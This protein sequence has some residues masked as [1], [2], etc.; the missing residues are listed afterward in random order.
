MKKIFNRN[1]VFL[2]LFAVT[3]I[4]PFAIMGYK[5]VVLDYALAGLMPVV[6][7]RV[8]LSMVVHGH[9]DDISIST[10]LPKT[11][12]RQKITD[13]ENSSGAFT[14]ALQSG[15]D[16]RLAT[17]NAESVS[18]EHNIRYT[19]S[20]QAGHVQYRIPP[21]MP[22]PKADARKMAE[23]LAEEAGTQVND[24]LIE[25]T[26]NEILPD[27]EVTLLEALTGIHRYLQ[28]S[29]KNKTFSGYT[30]A[31]TALKLGEASC[32]GKSRAFSAMLR[33]LN[34]PSR[35]VGGLI[36]QQGSKRVGHQWVEA[37]INGHWVP[38]DTINDHFAEIPSNY[39]TL[40]YGDLVLF[41]HTTNV[42]FQY[43]FKITKRL[44]PRLETQ[45]TL[46]NSM[47]NIFNI[48]SVFEQVGISQNL[49]KIMLMIPL[50]ALVTVVFRNVIG[51]ETFG[52]FLPALI[53]AAARETGLLWGVVGF[54]MVILVSALA[55]KVLDWLH[56]LH[57][58]K[59]AIMLTTVVVVML[60]TT[61]AGVRLGLFDLAHITLFPIAIMA[62]TAERFAILETEQGIKKAAMI[63][64]ATIVVISACYAVMD[65][66]F[67]QS[68][69][70]AF[71]ELLLVVIAINMWLG[72]WIGMR[73]MEFIRFRRLIFRQNT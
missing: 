57:S 42:N 62:I 26:L 6:S 30:D 71:P 1:K 47:L 9:G 21:D 13:E 18:G 50:G 4:L 73:L 43:F 14:M 23:Y 48:Y 35:L 54:V 56:L 58:P 29:V 49:L 61:V 34:I 22:I 60:S 53:A 17:W 8:E 66:L 20:A 51:L 59:M 45:E 10:Y 7:H 63:T 25:K 24:P 36:L 72:K 40:Y 68:M 41:K 19:F 65:S 46:G 39:L 2:A 38:F 44:V 52:T 64:L 55:R 69:F 32:N 67:L 3:V 12:S 11:D 27:R 15:P 28:D 31:V 37:Y 33:K 70:L 16:N 5:L